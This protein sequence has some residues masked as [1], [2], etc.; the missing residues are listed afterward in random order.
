MILPRHSRLLPVLGTLL[1]FAA[2]PLGA[3]DLDGLVKN[4]P[5]G[6]STSKAAEDAKPGTLEF[7]GMF[8]DHGVTYYSIYN[9]TTKQ[10]TWVKQGE[11]ADGPVP[12]VVKGY[13]ADNETL[14]LENG[15]QPVKVALHAATVSNFTGAAAIAS[16][17]PQ[18]SAAPAVGATTGGFAFNNGQPPSPEQI[19]AFRDE[20][21]KRF[22]RGGPGGGGDANGGAVT[23]DGSDNRALRRDRG[24]DSGGNA[25]TTNTNGNTNRTKTPK[26]K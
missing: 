10:S 7:R 8:A 13:D 17:P 14:L 24:N 26:S 6:A 4:S 16:L 15:G 3:I 5:F 25:A 22:G 23:G 21:R 18:G 11:A 9:A 2:A 19:Q 12:F 20:M 1:I